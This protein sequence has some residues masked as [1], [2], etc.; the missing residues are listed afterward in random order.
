[1]HQRVAAE[2]RRARLHL[3]GA[4]RAD[5]AEDGLV[6]HR[7]L[8]HRQGFVRADVGVFLNQRG[9]V[10]AFIRF[11]EVLHRESREQQLLLPD[12]GRIARERAEE[13]DLDLDYRDL[14]GGVGGGRGGSRRGLRGRGSGRGGLGRLGGR[15]GRRRAGRQQQRRD[16]EAA[17]DEHR[18]VL[19]FHSSISSEK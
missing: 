19:A 6:L 8:A 17:E 12:G 15:R 7:L 5:D 10:V 3:P 13:G 18:F 4:G 11:V 16:G 9:D 2:H 1:M 14:G